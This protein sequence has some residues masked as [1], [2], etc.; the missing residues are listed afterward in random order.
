MVC[1]S[2]GYVAD[3]FGIVCDETRRSNGNIHDCCININC[4][5]DWG[6]PKKAVLKEELAFC[7]VLGQVCVCSPLLLQTNGG[8]FSNIF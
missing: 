3:E 4:E 1:Y 7:F 2:A 8:I 5:L 6:T